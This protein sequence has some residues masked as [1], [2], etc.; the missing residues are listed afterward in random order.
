MNLL[1][2]IDRGFLTKSS[3]FAWAIKEYSE[4]N[5]E[6]WEFTK[7]KEFA[8]FISVLFFGVSNKAELSKTSSWEEIDKNNLALADLLE[9]E[10]V[11]GVCCFCDLAWIMDEEGGTLSSEFNL[12]IGREIDVRFRI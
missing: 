10:S 6:D 12:V 3:Y 7:N 9:I 11:L 8:L 4:D 1:L 5:E 2:V